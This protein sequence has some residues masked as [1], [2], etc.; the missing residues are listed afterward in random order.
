[1][2]EFRQYDI[3]TFDCY[4]TLIDWESG[5]LNA[6]NT[7]L[8]RH[9]INAENRILLEL[10]AKYESAAE[11]GPYIPY[12]EVLR[13][14][15]WQFGKQFSFVPRQ[16]D[17]FALAKSMQEWQP[18]DDTVESLQKLKQQYKLAVL[19]NVDDELFATSAEKLEVDFDFVITAQQL[20]C[21]KPSESFFRQ[22]IELMELPK[23]KILHTAQSLFH[24]IAPAQR[25][26][27][28]TVWMNRR[29]QSTGF[30]ATPESHVIPDYE[31]PDLK[32]F[33][34]STGIL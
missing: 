25:L 11:S 1:M 30:G 33:V 17:D 23:N 7:V 32:S 26:G 24:D 28:S 5:I 16:E 8:R 34:N 20:G 6:L 14:V 18:F 31:I 10:Y 15:M 3:I 12:R 22:V 13:S 27:L 29:S 4:G 19:S 21:Y 2:I 9:S